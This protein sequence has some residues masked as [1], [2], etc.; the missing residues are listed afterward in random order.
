MNDTKQQKAA[1]SPILK[2]L[3]L[4][5]R[6]RDHS[7]WELKQK[8][9]RHWTCEEVEKS[10]EMAKKKGWLKDEQELSRNWVQQMHTQSKSYRYIAAQLKKRG[11]PPIEKEHQREFEKAY[12]LIKKKKGNLLSIMQ[13]NIEENK[14][15]QE[16]LKSLALFLNHRGFDSETIERVLHLFS[17]S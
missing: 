9:K 14:N 11:L 4:L 13:K 3:S 17:S 16:N 2:R 1:S 12:S 5:L 7:A 6:Y 15:N 8:L 10:L